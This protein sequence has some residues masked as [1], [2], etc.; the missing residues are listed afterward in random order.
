MQICSKSGYCNQSI[1][2][3]INNCYGIVFELKTVLQLSICNSIVI[4]TEVF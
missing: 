1:G 2:H 4:I 3:I